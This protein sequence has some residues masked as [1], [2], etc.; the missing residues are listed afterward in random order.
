MAYELKRGPLPA[1]VRRIADEQ[2]AGAVAQ[3]SG[4]TGDDWDEAVHD[5]RKRF[6]KTRA[7][8]RLVR[9]DLGDE[10]YRRE[11]AFFRDAGRVLSP[12]RDAQVLVETLDALA[13]R[14]P[15]MFGDGTAD[16]LRQALVDRR[17][18]AQQHL[19]DQ[20][21]P[22]E[23]ADLIARARRRI[24]AWP[25]SRDGWEML[26]GG[27]RRQYRR[28]RRAFAA[29]YA[30]PD[31]EHFHEWRKRVKDHWYHLRILR[32]LWPTVVGDLIAEADALSDELGWEH[33]LGVLRRALLDDAGLWTTIKDPEALL[34]LIEGRRARL[35]QLAW[36]RGTRLYADKSGPFTARLEAY[37]QAW[38][39]RGAVI[40]R[41]GDGSGSR[42]G[43]RR[44]GVPPPAARPSPPRAPPASRPGSAGRAARRRS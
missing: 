28:G 3:L 24:A 27:L 4:E 14:F 37:W 6:K 1:E 36:L 30:Q 44:A 19:I 21:V 31:D 12:A 10:T 40:G 15:G 29:A 2:V 34:V 13:E 33:D 35:R 39:P 22:F 18:D 17:H 16:R 5:A 43:P 41:A 42:A 9:N 7:V 23:V 26:E 8:L 25:L 11:N 20:R 32:P 38:E